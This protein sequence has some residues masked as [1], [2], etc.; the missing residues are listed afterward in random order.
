[1]FAVIFTATIKQQDDEYLVTAERMRQIAMRDYGCL[2]FIASTE[3][4]LEIAISYWPNLE[5]IR[6]WRQNA[7]HLKAQALGKSKW[8]GD[9]HVQVVEVVREYHSRK[10][11]HQ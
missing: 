6:Q 5:A 4:D 10:S 1:M 7:E 2:E 11:G 3:G 8:Y 9:Y